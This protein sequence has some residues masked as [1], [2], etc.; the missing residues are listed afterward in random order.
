MIQ[1]I[2]IA[3]GFILGTIVLVWTAY[4]GMRFATASHVEA[5]TKELAGS[6]IFRVAALHGL[7]LALVFAQEMLEYQQLDAGIVSEATAVADIYYDIERY[8]TEPTE[9]MRAALATY[10]RVASSTEWASLGTERRLLREGWAWREAVYITL[11]DLTPETPRQEALR[12]HM[13]EKVQRIAEL[14]QA[15]ENSAITSISIMFWFAAA[16]GVVLVAMSFFCF[17]PKLLNLFLLSVFGAFT[18]FVM[19]IIYA[20]SNPFS[21]PGALQPTAFEQLLNGEIGGKGKG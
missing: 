5:E 9:N 19:L 17:P 12:D 13:L 10:L 2:F 8:G 1:T 4:F 16:F 3:G 7:I 20:F 15:R 11:L 18:G 14:R 6:V 21:P